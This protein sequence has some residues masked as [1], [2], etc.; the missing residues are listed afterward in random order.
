MNLFAAF[1]LLAQDPEPGG[2]ATRSTL[3][4]L[5][6]PPAWITGL[7]LLPLLVAIVAWTYRRDPTLTSRQKLTLALLRVVGLILILLASFRPALEITRNLKVRTEVHFLVDDSAS[8]GRQES[9]AGDRDDE[10]RRALGPEAPERLTD[11]TRSEIVRRLLGEGGEGAAT[12][13]APG[14]RAL[15]ATLSR[16]FDLRWFRFWDRSH[17]VT[18]LGE[19]TAKGGST[20]I[21]DTLDVHLANHA[22]ESSRMEAIVLVT[23]GRS[24]DGLPPRESAVR[25]AAAEIPIFA[26]GVGDPGSEQNLTLSGPPGPQ[27][28]LQNEEAV[29]ELSVIQRGMPPGSFQALVYAARAG[30]AGVALEEGVVGEVKDQQTPTL[31]GTGETRKFQM[32]CTFAEPGDYILTFD[33]PPLPGETNP[34]DNRTRRYLRVDSDKIRV[35]YLEEQP[36]W[37]YQFIRNA[38]K[39]VDKSILLQCFQ[40]DA[41]PRFPQET[42][43]DLPSLVAVPSTK[44]EL[45]QYHVVLLGDVPPA[46]L[47]DSEEARGNWLELLKSFVEHGGGLGVIAGSLAMP[48]RYRETTLED[49]LPVVVGDLG[50]EDTPPAS[51]ETFLPVPDNLHAPHPIVLLADDVD[52]NRRLWS[53]G[54]P[55]MTW[56]YPVLR[57]KAG[58]SVLLRHP[59]DENKYGPRALVALAPYPKG[60]VFF[61]A[62]DETWRWRKFYETKYQ[63]RYWR[64]VVRSLAENK[65]RRLDDRVTLT[66]D[67][68]EVDVGDSVR[69]ELSLLDE[70]YNPV[71]QDSA[72]LF[73]RA[74]QGKL[75][76]LIL[77]RLQGLAGRFETVLP[78]VESG[79]HSVLY[80]KDADAGGRPMARQDVVARVPRKELAETS[81]DEDLLKD[82]AVSTDGAYLPIARM[83][84]LLDEFKGRGA[85]LKTVD[86]KIREVWDAAWTVLGILVLVTAEWIL[87]KRWRLV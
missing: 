75:Q 66:V 2:I 41:S 20:R 35:L 10:L 4:W 28:V 9:Y 61:S 49:L 40:F 45:F 6:A 47:G 84:S 87:R 17:P 33:V 34:K 12:R 72:R 65:L 59:T 11:L 21:G 36:R 5:D 73:V 19:L 77:P 58:A 16:D 14:G 23:D 18:D 56:F 70:D 13:A 27:Q 30:E 44:A 15:L 26:L 37:E 3:R 60:K 86:R 85:G 38:L 52:V 57:A 39:R 25:L 76:S 54:L 63:D 69:V 67:H 53:D 68:E 64:N 31:P 71:L 50:E 83:A 48:E 62:V 42:T 46:R 24:N 7:V 1:W 74:P 80:Y 32:R 79:V 22:A 51:F 78:L 81:L 29:F 43:G 55:G 82:L 8:M